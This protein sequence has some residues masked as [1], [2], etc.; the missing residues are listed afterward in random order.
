MLITALIKFTAACILF[1]SY[2][3]KEVGPQKKC[4]SLFSVLVPTSLGSKW[5][6]WRRRTWCGQT[7]ESFFHP[8]ELEDGW[9][10]EKSHGGEQGGGIQGTQVFPF[11]HSSTSVAASKRTTFDLFIFHENWELMYVCH[12]PRALVTSAGLV[13]AIFLGLQDESTCPPS[14]GE[15]RETCVTQKRSE[16]LAFDFSP[17]C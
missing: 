11:K 8:C 4:I 2:S 12:T 10:M 16:W 5:W 15:A 3:A 17:S 6:R 9:R 14:E 13:F 1:S 7:K